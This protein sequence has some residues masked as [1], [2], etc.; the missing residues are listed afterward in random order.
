MSLTPITAAW[1]FKVFRL[2]GVL[3][4]LHKNGLHSPAGRYSRTTA[5]NY[6]FSIRTAISGS[7]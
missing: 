1:F 2:L 7:S 5:F 6:D 3:G 4:C